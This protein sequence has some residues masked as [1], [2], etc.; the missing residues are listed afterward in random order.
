MLK[1]IAKYLKSKDRFR[2]I[3]DREGI[4]DYLHRYYI[5]HKNEDKSGNEVKEYWFNAFLHNFKASDDPVF[6]DHPWAWCSI[7]LKGG[8]WEHTIDGSRT[9][10]GP[11]SMCF[12]S[13][14]DMHWVEL[15]PNIDTWTLFMHGRRKRNWG[16]L[17]G[18]DWIYWKDYLAERLANEKA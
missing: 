18:N 5:L 16:F 2:N 4:N 6:H 1:N 13:A 15:E 9:W 12:R 11:G 10:R 14:T 7:V 8:Y 3:P 17:V